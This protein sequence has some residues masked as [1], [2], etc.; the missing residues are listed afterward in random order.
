V[1]RFEET[2]PPY[3][4]FGRRNLQLR[5]PPINGTDVAVL[6][7]VCDPRLS[8]MNPPQGPMGSPIPITGMFDPSTRDA[9]VN[10]RDDFGLAVDGVADSQTHFAF[11]QGVGSHATCGGPVYGSRSLTPGHSGGAVTILPNRL[12]TFRYAAIIGHPAN[13]VYDAATANAALAFKQDAIANGQTGLSMN[14]TVGDGAFDASWLDTFAGGRGV[15][16]GRNGFDVAFLQVLLT[17]RGDDSGRIAGYCDAATLAA[18]RAI[19]HAEGITVDCQVVTFDHLGRHNNQAAPKPLA[20]AWP[21]SAPPVGFHDCCMVLQPQVPAQAPFTPPPG[22]TAWVRQFDSG[23]L[24]FALIVMNLPEP[25]T[26]DPSYN[27][28]V[29]EFEAFRLRALTEEAPS[30]GVWTF[31]RTQSYG[32]SV[33]PSASVI[34]RPGRNGPIEPLGPVVLSASF[35]DCH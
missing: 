15:L 23:S 13:G 21:P 9:V 35:S 11:G 5:S 29:L 18:V 2:F 7:A 26:F 3:V 14:T 10:A 33:P 19:Q 31:W 8:T 6:R 17:G 28:W 12:N 32:S 30:P 16:P 34:I 1:E 4:P 22:G 25:S 24:A 27:T 20:I